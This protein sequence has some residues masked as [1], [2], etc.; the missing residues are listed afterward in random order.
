MPVPKYIIKKMLPEDAFKMVDGR[1]EIKFINIVSPIQIL[2]I[3]ENLID[4]INVKIDGEDLSK[5]VLEKTEIIFEENVY[6]I[7]NAG[8]AIGKTLSVGQSLTIRL[9]TSNISPGEQHEFAISVTDTD[10]DFSVVRKVI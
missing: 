1:L 6:T 4:M 9:F 10:L 2:E 3:P 8:D 5:D 7:T